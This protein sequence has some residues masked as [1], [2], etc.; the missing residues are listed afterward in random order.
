M[1]MLPILPPEIWERVIDHLSQYPRALIRCGLVCRAWYARCRFHLVVTTNLVNVRAVYYF[2]SLIVTRPDLRN[3]VKQIVIRGSVRGQTRPPIPH[4]ETFAL[5]LAKNLPSVGTLHI[6][7][8]EWCNF[9]IRPNVFVA[10]ETFTAITELRL[11]RV[12]FPSRTVLARLIYALR[13]LTTLACTALA[14][15][16]QNYHHT[17]SLFT[18]T[19]VR[20]IRLD[21]PSDATADLLAC[22]MHIADSMEVF[23][24]GWSYNAEDSPG[25]GALAPMLERAGPTLRRV[26]IRLRRSPGTPSISITSTHGIKG[27]CMCH[28][29]RVALRL[30][31]E[32]LVIRNYQ[33]IVDS[34]SWVLHTA[35]GM[36][37]V[38]LPPEVCLK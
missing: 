1:S 31:T 15:R 25:E 28:K 24:A 12:T 34:E 33:R 38:L 29:V 14:F 21:G 30:A 11:L 13:N 35:Q 9:T 23:S 37:S 22:Q 32:G 8:A 18:R 3:R 10:L 26:N 36:L 6:Y 4:F 17:P 19:H 27:M 7:D 2:A 16:V 20:D 5:M